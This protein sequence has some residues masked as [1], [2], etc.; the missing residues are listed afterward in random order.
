MALNFPPVD[1]DDGNP[2]D[3]LLWTA[4]DGHQWQYDSS[5]PG[6]RTLAATG[7]SNIIY[8]GGLDLTQDP[9][10]QY[11][12]ILSGNQF[13]VTV[14]SDSVDNNLYPGLGGKAVQEGAIAMYDG[15]RWQS[16][17]TT[18]MQQKLFLGL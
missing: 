13:V 1:V 10:P 9:S 4:P 6:W 15:N 2:T 12:P 18:R 17:A 3:G 5:I 14:G 7:N 8:R 16:L 11:D